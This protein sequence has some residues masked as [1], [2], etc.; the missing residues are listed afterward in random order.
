M[1]KTISPEQ[2]AKELAK[3]KTNVF[4]L[5]DY[6]F[7]KQLDFVKDPS[8]FKAAVT[9][10]RAGKSTSCVADL[11]N[12]AITCP[13]VICLYITLSRKNA[14]RL[15][16]PEFK[17]INRRY[18]LGGIVNESDLT[19]T[20]PNDSVIYISG[21]SDRTEIENFRGMAIKK[22][23]I[24]EG[25]SF[26]EYIRDLIDDV[27]GP[28][29][30][31][32]AGTLCLIGTPGPI[33]AGYFYDMSNSKEW[34]HHFWS[35]F[36]NPFIPLKSGKSHQELLD[37]ELK[38][39]GVSIDNPSIQREWFGR[40]VLDS[41]SLVFKYDSIKSSYEELPKVK[42]NYILGVDL[43]FNDADALAVLA[44]SEED[45]T[46]YLVEELITRHQGVTEL[47]EQVDVLKKK[48]DIA[49]I[50]VD[51]GGLGK[52]IAEELSR[53]YKTAVQPAEK[54]RKIEFIE[55][56][57]DAL[58]TGKLK[59]PKSSRFAQDCMRVE[60]DMDKS[61]PD[62]RVISSRYHSDICDSVLYSWR[63]C[64]SFTHTPKVEKPKQGSKQWLEE[65]EEQ[66]LEFFLKQEEN[67]K[68]PYK[69]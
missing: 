19:I 27:L 22:V 41:D 49:K 51:T 28:A 62:K 35:F 61:T 17:R 6:L 44:W 14:K 10:R 30:M 65:L 34:S 40:W 15:V 42:W 24:D 7:G 45:P 52:K 9:T 53:R 64:Y 60:W 1:K 13:N 2:A 59:A 3:R 25:Q 12:E 23:Y 32:Y 38:R 11:T 33:P 29:L 67:D 50:V 56:M 4:R 31:D 26:P 5:E 48:Y 47:I 46:A 69:Y 21:A 55:L 37:R 8:H 58:R 66:A 16:W 63:E 18:K 36:D 57:N 39:R 20:F 43:G 54:I 68:D